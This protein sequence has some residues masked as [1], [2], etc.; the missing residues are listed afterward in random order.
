MERENNNTNIE[1]VLTDGTDKEL[2]EIDYGKKIALNVSEIIKPESVADKL[3][4][5]SG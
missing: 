5:Y 1:Y 2:W 4:T 3:T